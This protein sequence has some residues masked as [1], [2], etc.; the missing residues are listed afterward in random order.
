MPSTCYILLK[1][2]SF[3]SSKREAWTVFLAEL[4]SRSLEH[5]VRATPT[6]WLMF[7]SSESLRPCTPGH[8]EDVPGSL[9]FV[10]V[11][12]TVPPIV[13]VDP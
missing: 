11:D 8:H 12:S 6:T 3:L 9:S 4:L 10:D 13:D 1:S 7:W 5:G 2:N